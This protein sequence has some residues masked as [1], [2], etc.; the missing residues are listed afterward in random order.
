ML[1]QLIKE[2][3]ILVWNCSRL[4][5]KPNIVL[6]STHT[7]IQQ[8]QFGNNYKICFAVNNINEGFVFAIKKNQVAQKLFQ[9]KQ[10][11]PTS[12]H[13]LVLP[14]AWDALTHR[15]YTI[16]AICYGVEIVIISCKP[17]IQL[18]NAFRIIG[19]NLAA[20]ACKKHL[21]FSWFA[22]SV[23][24]AHANCIKF[25]C[26]NGFY[27]SV[28]SSTYLTGNSLNALSFSKMVSFKTESFVHL[29]WLSDGILL[30]FTPSES[31]CLLDSNDGHMI[32]AAS[33][34]K[35]DISVA[36]QFSE[37]SD[38]TYCSS[39]DL[40]NVYRHSF[41]V[42]DSVYIICQKKIIGFTVRTLQEVRYL[43]MKCATHT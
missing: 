36:F 43:Y 23:I 39:D 3:Q 17:I 19:A 27:I 1:W 13:P 26:S 10:S 5:S 18:I 30:M 22:P 20:N 33:L 15:D 16:L 29:S 42:T 12:L 38:E 2:H 37:L 31:L 4:T 35:H 32:E 28:F 9:S 11:L 6:F 34:Q 24:D 21:L 41:C 40:V 8:I 25:A 14:F 7:H